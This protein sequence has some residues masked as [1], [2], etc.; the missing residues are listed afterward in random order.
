[1]VDDQANHLSDHLS[2]RPLDLSLS[3]RLSVWLIKNHK[4]H[5]KIRKQALSLALQSLNKV[6]KSVKPSDSEVLSEDLQKVRKTLFKLFI[7]AYLVNLKL[8]RF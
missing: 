4:K 1:M 6:G 7:F 2:D 8:F 5:R 3:G